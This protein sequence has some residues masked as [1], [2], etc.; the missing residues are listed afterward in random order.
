MGLIKSA[1]QSIIGELKDQWKDYI[2]CEDMDMNTLMVKKTTKTGIISKSSAIMVAPG[3]IAVIFDSGK[4]LDATAE[5][6]TYTFDESSAPSFFAG[7]FG[8]V[9]K[10][11]WARFTYNGTV[12]KQQAVFYINAKEIIDN[13]FGTP[14]P[15]PFQD[16][17]HPIPNEMTGTITP[18]RVQVKCFGKYTYK[19][20]DPAV[21][22]R[23]YAGTGDVVTK[24]V[25]NEQMRSEVIASFQNVLNELGTEAHKVPVLELPSRTDE[26][27]TTMD[28]K[29]Y[30]EPIRKRGIQ[31]TGFAIESVTLDDESNKKIDEYE[32]NSNTRMQQGRVL[33]V[34]ETAAGNPNGAGTGFMG[35]G[36]MNMASGGMNTAVMQNAFT[37]QQ[38]AQPVGQ[39]P[40]AA[41]VAEGE[42]VFCPN[43]GTK[44]AGK[45]CMSCGTKVHA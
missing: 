3:Q 41:P 31:I 2:T 26:I 8:A 11:L 40:A 30:D 15:V 38:P 22:M 42:G 28:E 36:M 1:I 10:D 29:V 7:Q 21:F 32:H 18:L 25:L 6:G 23:E 27:K 45:F 17:S 43:C 4:I 5:E 13:K 44:G 37:P 16:Y 24:D 39:A 20:S 12:P 14:A 9:F 35:L 19:I 34:M 33:N